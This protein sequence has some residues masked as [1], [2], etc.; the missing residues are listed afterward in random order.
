MHLKTSAIRKAAG[1]FRGRSQLGWRLLA[2]IGFVG[3][4][5]GWGQERVLAQSAAV[6]CPQPPILERFQQHTVA[7]G[8]TLSQIAQRY[9]LIP[10]TIM[11][12]N[13]AVRNQPVQSGQRLTIPPY[14]GILVAL[15]SGG[16]LQS[17]ATIYNVRPDILFE[18]NGCQRQPKVVFVPGI[19]WSPLTH[20]QTT[21]IV[22]LPSQPVNQ[23]APPRRQDRYPL[24]QTALL[25]KP[26]GW[27]TQ[28]DGQ[29]LVF[30]SG[31]TLQAPAGAAVYA[32]AAGTV[33][34]AGP[35]APWGNLVV[36]N[37]AEGRQTRYG[38]LSQPKVGV[39]QPVQRGQILG[40]IDESGAGLRFE[41]RQRSSVGWVAQDPYPYLKAIAPTPLTEF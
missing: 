28:P 17:V 40:A 39:G 2:L 9:G 35:Q 1:C 23:V 20:G 22:P 37:H 29:Q 4:G 32:V 21:A 6:A 3:Q 14:N 33:A 36:V 31:V 13:P 10:A 18:V 26:Y 38:Y 8:E 16:T 24:A 5:L 12:L 27:Q 11:G 7:P 15:P 19:N 25:Q 41:L 34:F 30:S